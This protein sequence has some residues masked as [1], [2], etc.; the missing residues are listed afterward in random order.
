MPS[1]VV[2][3]INTSEQTVTPDIVSL[4]QRDTLQEFSDAAGTLCDDLTAALEIIN[5]DRFT[6]F[7]KKKQEQTERALAEIK[8]KFE[9]F[10]VICE[11]E[12]ESGAGYAEMVEKMANDPTL[13]VSE[14]QREKLH[15]LSFI[16]EIFQRNLTTYVEHDVNRVA[17]GECRDYWKLADTN[18]Y[19]I[20]YKYRALNLLSKIDEASK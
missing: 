15:D 8:V 10:K 16:A 5:P 13:S 3:N 17:S 1:K 2:K 11:R 14:E 7:K 4:I 9:T 12:L 18:E 20:K 6:L 19:L